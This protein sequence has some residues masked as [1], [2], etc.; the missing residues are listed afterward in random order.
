MLRQL[1]VI[2]VLVVHIVTNI[3]HMEIPTKV[4]ELGIAWVYGTAQR[5]RRKR[6][7]LFSDLRVRIESNECVCILV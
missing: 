6:M 5:Q 3:T 7:Q 2:Y 1:V 4:G